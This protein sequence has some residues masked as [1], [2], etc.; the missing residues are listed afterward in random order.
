MTVGGFGNF[1]AP[2]KASAVAPTRTHARAPL[3]AFRV[4]EDAEDAA[5]ERSKMS[6]K[7]CG[8]PADPEDRRAKE[9]YAGPAFH[10]APPPKPP[11][12]RRLEHSWQHEW[13]ASDRPPLYEAPKPNAFRPPPPAPRIPPAAAARMAGLDSPTVRA[14]TRDD[15]RGGDDADDDG[16]AGATSPAG[17][18]DSAEAVRAALGLSPRSP[19]GRADAAGNPSSPAAFG[20]VVMAKNALVPASR[21]F[22]DAPANARNA[23]E[24]RASLALDP[25]KA[26]QERQIGDLMASLGLNTRKKRRNLVYPDA[27]V[28]SAAGT[29]GDDARESQSQQRMETQ[30]FELSARVDVASVSARATAFG[31]AMSPAVAEARASDYPEAGSWGIRAEVARYD[32]AHPGGFGSDGGSFVG[33]SSD[34]WGFAAADGRWSSPTGGAR[35]EG[36]VGAGLGSLR[37]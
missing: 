29:A 24:W 3:D 27:F 6:C 17:T 23:A 35:R 15:A 21:A 33:V 7:C 37:R 14:P 36:G 1:S 10:L 32:A 28:A 30:A 19:G 26:R 12:P 9:M 4:A 34:G 31:P 22:A 11:A 5:E 20:D 16:A 8:K 13:D 18:A 2:P 25:A